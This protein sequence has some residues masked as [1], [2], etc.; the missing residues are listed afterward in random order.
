MTPG[1]EKVLASRLDRRIY[2][3][4][5]AALASSQ[6]AHS[7]AQNISSLIAAHLEAHDLSALHASSDGER[8][9]VATMYERSAFQPLWV[10]A[11]G[12]RT[13]RARE[14]S[15][16]LG[17]ADDDGLDPGDYATGSLNDL[18][19]ALDLAA[20]PPLEWAARYELALSTAMLR[21]LGDVRHGA[22]DP[23]RLGIALPAPVNRDDDVVTCL[24]E[25]VD[26]G[27]VVGAVECSRPVINDY[28]LLRAA[29]DRYRRIAAPV[30]VW[31]PGSATLHPG[32]QFKGA[33]QLRARLTAFG[34]LSSASSAGESGVYGG[35][36]V[37]GIKR[38]QSRHGLDA[39]GVIGRATWSELAVPAERRARQIELALE[40]LRWLPHQID[41]P[42]LVLNI[43]MFELRG[44]D[45]GWRGAPAFMMKAI[46]GR[47]VT[48]TLVLGATL[49][50]VIFR[51]YW[52]VPP[53]IL[54]DELLPALRKDPRL[55]ERE[56]MQIV[57]GAGD[58]ARPVPATEDN[59]A[60]LA[61]GALRLRQRPGP[62]NA[63]GLIKFMLPNEENVY[64][65]GTPAQGLFARNQRAFSHGCVR[66]ED[67][68]AL[69]EW[70][71][72]GSG[73]WSRDRI[74]QTISNTT[75]VSRPVPAPRQI[76][77]MLVY[78]TAAAAADGSVRFAADIYDKDAAL[79]WA[80]RSRR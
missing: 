18:A 41:G 70:V 39:D 78:A 8:A 48:P 54:R 55:L 28:S 67:P 74:L 12:K 6:Y 34:D 73:E 7:S 40:R 51:P 53:S 50:S 27:S 11:A 58:D 60:R 79:D 33:A 26:R 15:E 80:L 68:A 24:R 25:A 66:V 2:L 65:H 19:A 29:L 56:N 43:P 35:A 75:V 52:N 4:L 30:D 14:A 5:T 31:T 44:W 77:V 76:Q 16:I 59:L 23:R 47:P 17:N 49:E 64:L 45:D 20:Y 13:V 69:A 32:D 21:Y 10:D 22:I 38:F 1:R 37:D 72:A 9:R 42:L 36:L 61:G 62:K 63:L 3:L 57:Q 46:V 71:L